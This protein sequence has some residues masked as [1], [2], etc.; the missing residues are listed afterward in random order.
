MYFFKDIDY[1]SI[2]DFGPGDLTLAEGEKANGYKILT[3]SPKVVN[4][5]GI[6]QHISVIDRIIEDQYYNNWSRVVGDI[7]SNYQGI[8]SITSQIAATEREKKDFLIESVQYMGKTIDELQVKKAELQVLSDGNPR[9]LSLN[10]LKMLTSGYIYT[11]VMP[12]EKIVSEN[13]LPYINISFLKSISKIDQVTE[14]GL[15]VVSNDHVYAAFTIPENESIMGEELVF[16]LKEEL[17]GTSDQGINQ[18]YY[19][20]LVKRID[21]LHYYPELRFMYNDKVYS[22]YFVDIINEGNQKIIVLLIKDYVNDFAN[23]VTKNAEIYIQD[24]RA[25]EIPKSAVFKSEEQT[26]VDMLTKGYFSEPTLVDVEKYNNRS[27]VLRAS[28][29]PNLKTGMRIRVNP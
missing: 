15:K 11:S 24:Y 14:T 9:N 2:D 21:Q 3:N 4:V 26:Y 25:F 6:N 17:M 18:G 29:N 16:P 13:M 5:E 10:E 20:F 27:A 8:S 28:Q 22:G 1:I 23:A 12:V 19:D 7:V